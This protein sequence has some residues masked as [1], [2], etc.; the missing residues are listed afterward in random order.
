VALRFVLILPDEEVYRQSEA[1]RAARDTDCGY[2]LR[3][4]VVSDVVLVIVVAWGFDVAV[5]NVGEKRLSGDCRGRIAEFHGHPAFKRTHKC[6][7]KHRA[8][9][10]GSGSSLS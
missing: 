2:A 6:P 1:A 8:E 3:A 5:F 4:R 7:S 9:H 10:L